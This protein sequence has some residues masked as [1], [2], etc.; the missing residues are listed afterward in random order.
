MFHAPAFWGLL[1]CLPLRTKSTDKTP[2]WTVARR[3][4]AL[5]LRSSSF[6]SGRL[7]GL[8]SSEPES[9]CHSLVPRNLPDSAGLRFLGC[10]RSS[11]VCH[12]ATLTKARSTESTGGPPTAAVP[13]FPRGVC[14]RRVR[15]A[16]ARRARAPPRA[17]LRQA[18][19]GRSVSGAGPLQMG[20]GLWKAV[21]SERGLFLKT[22][23]P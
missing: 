1:S 11:S 9:K 23:A 3:G 22:A 12:A 10:D 6:A 13:V 15:A 21:E 14:A 17:H 18:G 4:Q 2:L 16:C 5:F 7:S 19:V 20:R 8:A